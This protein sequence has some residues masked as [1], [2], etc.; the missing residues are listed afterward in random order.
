MSDLD[1][2][3]NDEDG[4]TSVGDESSNSKNGVFIV[5]MIFLLSAAAAILWFAVQGNS[6]STGIADTLA[7]TVEEDFDT[8]NQ[9]LELPRAPVVNNRVGLLQRPVAAPPPPPDVNIES[10]E[11]AQA[12]IKKEKEWEKRRQAETTVFNQNN[13]GDSNSSNNQ[14][15]NIDRLTQ[16]VRDSVSAG[17]L[18]GRPAATDRDQ[19]DSRLTASRTTS[20]TASILRDMSHTLAEGT[21]LGCTLETAIDT[22]LPGKVRCVLA[23]DVYSFD[24]RVL[25][26][27]KGSRV[28]GEY[29][30]GLQAGEARTFVIWTRI[31]TYSGIDIRLNSP[32]TDQLGRSGQSLYVNTH[33]F[34]RFGAS[35]LLSILGAAAASEGEDDIRIEEI[36]N[37]FNR[38]AEIALENSI[39]I[40]PT[41]SA[42][43]GERIRIFVAQDIDF[44]PALRVARK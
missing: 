36:G 35:A 28:N 29:E 26:A 24:G 12:R 32:S 8:S 40:R 1:K 5:G 13:R 31:I 3:I 41:G 2:E 23:E 4:I 42:N 27:E 7:A 16:N 43:Q 11:Q 37:S 44:G 9:K 33:F 38:S 22:T 10:R 17:N 21:S 30:G 20:V 6:V 39:N 19:L 14:Q 25:L 34:E 15:D 18:G